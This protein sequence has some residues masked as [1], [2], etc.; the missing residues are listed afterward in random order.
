MKFNLLSFLSKNIDKNFVADAYC[1][2]ELINF[3]F[4]MMLIRINILLN[5]FKYT[6]SKQNFIL[7][8]KK[9]VFSF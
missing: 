9:Y 1:V 8:L 6:F 2:F 4:L 3:V 7:D 5:L